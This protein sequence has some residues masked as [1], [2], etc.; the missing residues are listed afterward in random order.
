MNS[1]VAYMYG[2]KRKRVVKKKKNFNMWL[3]VKRR[4]EKKN[5]SLKS[6]KLYK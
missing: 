1:K 6:K 2:C 4:S 5:N 3:C